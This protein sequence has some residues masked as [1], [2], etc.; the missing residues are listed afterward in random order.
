[1]KNELPP[2][3][4]V[5]QAQVKQ[6]SDF[7]YGVPPALNMYK[8]VYLTTFFKCNSIEVHAIL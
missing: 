6:I 7:T 4:I 3:N 8:L 1:V 2:I 5:L